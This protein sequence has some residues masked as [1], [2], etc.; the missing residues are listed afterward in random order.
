MELSLFPIG[1][2]R[3][4]SGSELALPVT[5]STG[6]TR[7]DGPPGGGGE[8]WFFVVSIIHG[9]LIHVRVEN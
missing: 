5:V 1:I 2:T 6:G 8:K 9:E 4:S 3:A 7:V